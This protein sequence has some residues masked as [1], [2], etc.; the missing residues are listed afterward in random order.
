MGP[1]RPEV[2]TPVKR[3]MTDSGPP[4]ARPGG[5]VGIALRRAGGRPSASV[6][7]RTHLAGEEYYFTGERPRVE[8]ERNG[9]LC[10]PR[11]HTGAMDAQFAGSDLCVVLGEVAGE[12]V[13]LLLGNMTY[14][15]LPGTLRLRGIRQFV[16][17]LFCLMLVGAG[18]VSDR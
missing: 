15:V 17:F 8:W 16:Y 3:V 5:E 7:V 14:P 12:A 13:D 18:W 9:A 1:G 11:R 4:P 2:H 10:D 6:P